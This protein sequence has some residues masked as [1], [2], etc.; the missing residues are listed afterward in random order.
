MS[1]RPSPLMSPAATYTPP[2][3]AGPY[4]RKL[5]SSW[6]SIPLNTRTCELPFGPG[7]GDDVGAPVAV[8][9][10]RRHR[11][12]AGKPGI[13][14]VEAAQ[15]AQVGP[16]QD[17]DVRPTAGPGAG[18]Q[19]QRAVAVDV[20]NG[21]IDAAQRGGRIWRDRVIARGGEQPR[22]RTV[23]RTGS[24][25]HRLRRGGRRQGQCDDGPT[26][27]QPESS[28]VARASSF[29]VRWSK[30]RAITKGNS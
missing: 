13:V 7:P 3:N 25:H 18:D 5:A 16:A 27:I 8:D 24:H 12:A 23:A 15:L 11:H 21:H 17:A 1:V 6:R 4:A 14:G 2:R 26:G 29:G 19:I 10:A 30:L 28:C 20:T 9:V 22:E